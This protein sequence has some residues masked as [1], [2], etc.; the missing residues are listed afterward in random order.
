MSPAKTSGSSVKVAVGIIGGSA[1]VALAALCGGVL[2]DPSES[3]TANTTL[4]SMTTP[5]ST[6]T[7]TQAVPSITGKA[8]LFAG[9]APNANPQG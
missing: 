2:A 5:P 7:I 9:E 6:P 1:V 4:V 8:P 3:T